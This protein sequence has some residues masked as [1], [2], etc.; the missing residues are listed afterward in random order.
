MSPEP[1]EAGDSEISVDHLLD[2]RVRLLQPRAGYRAA[3]DPVLLAAAVP[4]VAGERVLDIGTGAAAAA[5]C[6][7]ARVPGAAVVGLEAQGAMA[8]LAR[9]NVAANGLE[10]RV[11]IVDG[12]LLAPPPALAPGS[13]HRVM[14][15]PPFQK[16]G[17]HTAAPDPGKAAAH[18]EGRAGL[19][20]WIAFAAAM[21]RPR[22]T[23]TLIHRA[24]RLDEIMA[25]LHGRFGGI[26][27]FPLW[28]RAGQPARRILVQARR[29]VRSPACLAAGLV[30][31]GVEGKFTSEAEAVLRHAQALVLPAPGP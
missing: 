1:E 19:A 14:A 15:N 26:V 2:R 7:A 29:G 16:A 3:I 22:G 18:G 20:E 21:V 6:L 10:S 27:L 30:L 11:A 8:D 28:P 25:L 9:R 24:D 4:A 5:L 12:D 17:A 13:F 23:L 31:H